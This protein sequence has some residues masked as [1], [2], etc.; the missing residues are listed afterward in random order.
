MG[1]SQKNT[2]EWPGVGHYIQCEPEFPKY[3]GFRVP[4][5]RQFGF[6]NEWNWAARDY[7]RARGGEAERKPPM[8]GFS[9]KLAFGRGYQG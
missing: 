7:S 6:L 8:G 5:P 4:N 1:S 3:P 2:P 9:F